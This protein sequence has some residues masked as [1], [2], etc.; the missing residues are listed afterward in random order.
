M[1]VHDQYVAMMLSSGCYM[2]PVNINE[3]VG[4]QEKVTDLRGIGWTLY[5]SHS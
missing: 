2:L 3:V 5:L 4:S 1:I